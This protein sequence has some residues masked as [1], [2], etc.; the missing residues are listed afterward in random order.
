MDSISEIL[1]GLCGGGDNGKRTHRRYVTNESS[2]SSDSD[3][4]PEKL[5]GAA[6]Q[7]GNGQSKKKKI[8]GKRKGKIGNKGKKKADIYQKSLTINNLASWPRKESNENPKTRHSL[9]NTKNWSIVYP[10]E[11]KLDIDI[12]D[13]LVY[14]FNAMKERKEFN[15]IKTES[16]DKLNHLILA[17]LEYK[18]P[19]GDLIESHGERLDSAEGLDGPRMTKKRFISVMMEIYSERHL[20]RIYL[21]IFRKMT[22]A[23]TRAKPS[24]DGLYSSPAFVD[25]EGGK[26]YKWCVCGKSPTSPFCDG[27]PEDCG[28]YVHPEIFKTEEEKG[29]KSYGYLCRCGLTKSPPYCDGSHMRIG[30][31][32]GQFD[33]YSCKNRIMQFAI[34]DLDQEDLYYTPDTHVVGVDW[35]PGDK[36]HEDKKIKLIDHRDYM[37]APTHH[38]YSYLADPDT[39]DKEV[40]IGSVK[41]KAIES[42][43]R[44]TVVVLNQGSIFSQY[45]NGLISKEALTLYY[46]PPNVSGPG[47]LI[48]QTENGSFITNLCDV[49]VEDAKFDKALKD[50]ELAAR[51]FTLTIDASLYHVIGYDKYIRD[52]WVNGLNRLVKIYAFE[53]PVNQIYSHFIG[54]RSRLGIGICSVI[55][56][57]CTTLALRL[58]PAEELHWQEWEGPKLSIWTR[59]DFVFDFWDVLDLRTQTDTEL[60]IFS[61]LLRDLLRLHLSEWEKCDVAFVTVKCG[62]LFHPIDHKASVTP[63]VV[64]K[65]SDGKLIKNTPFCRDTHI[66]DWYMVL[67]LLFEPGVESTVNF[68]VYNYV[69]GSDGLDRRSGL[70]VRMLLKQVDRE[71]FAVRRICRAFLRSVTDISIDEGDAYEIPAADF[72]AAPAADR[73]EY[74]EDEEDIA[75]ELFIQQKQLASR[76]SEESIFFDNLQ[77]KLKSEHFLTEFQKFLSLVGVKSKNLIVGKQLRVFEKDL[78]GELSINLNYFISKA[79]ATDNDVVYR[80]NGNDVATLILGIDKAKTLD[81]KRR[82]YDYNSNKIPAMSKMAL[83]KRSE[84]IKA[85]QFQCAVSAR[86]LIPSKYGYPRSQ[87]IFGNGA[88]LPFSSTEIVESTKN[89]KFQK[90]MTF[91]MNEARK[92][93]T[94]I[95]RLWDLNRQFA[96]PV[97]SSKVLVNLKHFKDQFAERDTASFCLANDD[98]TLDFRL[99]PRPEQS[100]LLKLSVEMVPEPAKPETANMIGVLFDG[101]DYTIL[102]RTDVIS[103]RTSTSMEWQNPDFQVGV[104]RYAPAR[105]PDYEGDEDEKKKENGLTLTGS[106]MFGLFNIK[107]NANTKVKIGH[108]VS[109]MKFRYDDLFRIVG[110]KHKVRATHPDIKAQEELIH[111]NCNMAAR[112][113]PLHE[114]AA[115]P[116]WSDNIT[117]AISPD[118]IKKLSEV[119]PIS[120]HH[121]PGVLDM[122]YD[123]DNEDIGSPRYY[124]E[125]PRGIPVTPG[126]TGGKLRF[127]KIVETNDANQEGGSNDSETDDTEGETDGSDDESSGREEGEQSKSKKNRKN[128]KS[129]KNSKP[130][131]SSKSGKINKSE[132]K[133]SRKSSK[134]REVSISKSSKIS[135]S[136]PRVD[137][138]SISRSTR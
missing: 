37:H 100:I 44:D 126:T 47:S 68:S 2:D 59:N 96:V 89:P 127:V 93:D 49:S 111:N 16:F 112:I 123:S 101:D 64:V 138:V 26:E 136:G 20:K 90:V 104:H 9:Q 60:K 55:D 99:I 120:M 56:D 75:V 109:M 33:S 14:L 105:Y 134:S 41:E 85:E 98:T 15:F 62:S 39:D 51:S 86:N 63:I 80:L 11:V 129:G 43:F 22:S 65:D 31:D 94:S 1:S 48:I 57:M 103:P 76:S 133:K 36:V 7:N 130:R 58:S 5:N 17:Q 3:Y 34:N 54:S 70:S 45:S 71:T 74:D 21:V 84:R 108:L 110:L 92:Q 46:E 128:S 87:V 97:C 4:A 35:G 117:I 131:K 122:G 66:P 28:V 40:S 10:P 67:Q 83:Y 119:P 82:L 23:H 42:S 13:E 113:N 121:T 88:G 32:E 95:L 78:L 107:K 19:A 125:S 114:S 137:N 77:R 132:K 115:K 24:N 73:D 18:L 69:E 8:L 135:R 102:G 38:R 79:T 25:L 27:T 116:E 72:S 124:V 53:E 106:L 29:V 81:H 118:Q 91:C 30:T 12:D 6:S 50:K 52:L 61:I